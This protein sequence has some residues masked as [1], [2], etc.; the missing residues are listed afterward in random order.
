HLKD[1]PN[2]SRQPGSAVSLFTFTGSVATDD[3]NVL[4]YLDDL[5]VGT[6]RKEALPPFVAPGRRE[7]FA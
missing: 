6:S 1:Q 3:S 4:Y 7:L 2:A 5:W